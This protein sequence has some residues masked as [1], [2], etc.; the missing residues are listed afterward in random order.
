M[1]ERYGTVWAH[2]SDSGMLKAGVK[3]KDQMLGSDFIRETEGK[4]IK[5]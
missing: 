4:Q 1:K 5:G 2:V 3:V